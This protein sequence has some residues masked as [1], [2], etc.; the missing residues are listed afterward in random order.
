MT[1][2]ILIVAAV[3]ENGVIGRD[4]Q[5]PWHLPNDFRRLVKLT[6]GKPLIMGRKTFES[7]P[8]LQRGRRHIVITR[9][10]DWSSDGAEVA[11]SLDHALTI[12]NA[13]EVAIFGGA[14]VY[15]QALPLASRIE[16]TRVHAVVDG[17]AF[18]PPLGDNWTEMCR[19]EIE[20]EEGNPPHTFVTLVRM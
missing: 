6:M 7:L 20:A 11:M 18:M 1:P 14:Q 5:M 2:E 12:A 16:L 9:N 4:N 15:A 13:P 10:E 19:E 3:A 8:G 17:D